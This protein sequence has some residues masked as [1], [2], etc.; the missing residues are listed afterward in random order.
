M[1]AA[2][3]SK[4][5]IVGGTGYLGKRLVRA[6]LAE[7]QETYVLYRPE[8]GLD[9]DKVQMLLSFKQQGARLVVASFSDHKSLVDAVKLVD[10]VI[11]AISGVHI[12]SHQILLQLKL[13]DAIKEAG[14]VKRFLP[15]EFGTDP[16]KMENAM[17]PGRVTFDDKMVVRKAIEVAGI[18][19]TYVSANCF[20]G[21]FL[22][23]LCQPGH[24]LPSKDHVVLLGDGNQKAIYVDEDDIA[25]YTI[26]TIDD[27]RTLNKTLYL[28]PPE[29]ILS[30]REV[31]QIWEKVIGKELL[32]SSLS[33]EEFLAAMKE[34]DF[35]EQVGLTHYYHVCYEGCLTNFEIGADG[36]EA[37]K[38]Y[39]QVKY[40]TVVDYLQRYL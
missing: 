2:K 35:A 3:K 12:R 11:C 39:P 4:V 38:L 10:V 18:P 28:R 23:G 30:Q 6:S 29:N 25:M 13:V 9:I 20:A 32:K 16:A 26:K 37:S 27:P 24:I 40:T 1:A 14:N 8:I 33:K 17:E 21:Y 34:Q 15:S 31:V 19:H 36:E 22:G 5:L 7:G